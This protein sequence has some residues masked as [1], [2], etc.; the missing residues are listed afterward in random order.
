[1]LERSETYLFWL[2]FSKKIVAVPFSSCM[3]EQN[4][5]EFPYASDVMATFHDF[6]KLEIR[7]G[8]IIT[9]EDFPEARNPS[10]KLTIDFGDCTKRSSA[11]L[12]K[13]YTKEELKEK[14]ILAVTNFPPKQIGP[15]ISEVLVVGVPDNTG[16]CVLVTPDSSVPLGGRLY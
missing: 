1:M 16:Q 4:L 15:F 3:L 9:V 13:N 2:I 14:M 10:Y 12:T 6:Q 8:K 11:Q 5:F 7:I